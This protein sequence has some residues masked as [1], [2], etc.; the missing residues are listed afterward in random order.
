[1]ID[2][3]GE[4]LHIG[5][6]LPE[7]R[8]TESES[9]AS[10]PPLAYGHRENI[11]TSWSEN[12]WLQSM[13]AE[14]KSRDPQVNEKEFQRVLRDFYRKNMRILGRSDARNGLKAFAADINHNYSPDNSAVLLWGYSSEFFYQFMKDKIGQ[15]RVLKYKPRYHTLVDQNDR[16]VDNSSIDNI[17]FI[18]DWVLSA[19]HLH[20]NILS[21]EVPPSKLRPY[22]L[23]MSD[24]GVQTCITNNIDARFVY[25]IPR[26][27]EN[28]GFKIGRLDGYPIYGFHKIPDMIP[29]VFASKQ[30]GEVKWGIFP[31][32]KGGFV[33]KDTRLSDKL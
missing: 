30:S 21:G 17:L 7:V 8:S 15:F 27:S 11:I 19:G 13:A 9:Q 12:S 4:L 23:V 32:I 1:M 28:H 31:E 25:R 16:Q 10:L 26:V 20:D 33:G 3:I 6:R 22:F 24:T 5:G 29:N 18:D 14:E 2:N